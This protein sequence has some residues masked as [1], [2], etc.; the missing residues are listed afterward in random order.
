[1]S[2]LEG[3]STSPLCLQ[4]GPT[5]VGCLFGPPVQVKQVV[6]WIGF[7]YEYLSEEL[8]HGHVGSATTITVKA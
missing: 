2:Y 3:Y 5:A 4:G 8:P 1:M 7:T 6:A